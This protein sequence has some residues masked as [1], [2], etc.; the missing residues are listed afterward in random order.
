M[1]FATPLF[2][3]ALLTSGVIHAA[4]VNVETGLVDQKRPKKDD[5]V[6][7]KKD[8]GL[9]T[10]GLRDTL[11][12]KVAKGEKRNVY[13]VIN[14]LGKGNAPSDWWVQNEVTR[15]GDAISCDAQ[16]G[17]EDEGAGE[18]FAI[19]AIATDKKWSVGDKLDTLPEDA[20]F[21]KVK[22]VKRK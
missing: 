17:E 7:P 14:P 20:T 2:L 1:R 9:T 8:D 12:G 18:Y 5:L 21:S 19:V 10:V 11:K 4:D 3:A 16:F 22:I 6:A 15:D 13:F